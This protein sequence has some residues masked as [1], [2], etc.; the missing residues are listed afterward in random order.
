MTGLGTLPHYHPLYLGMA[1]IHGTERANAALN[2]CDLLIAVGARFSDRLN[3]TA[4]PKIIHIDVDKTEFGKNVAPTLT[5]NGDAKSVLTRL[6]PLSEG[7]VGGADWGCRPLSH[8]AAAESGGGNSQLILVTDVGNH[9]IAAAKAFPI[10]RPRQFISS[11]GLG[12]MGFG[13]GA[14]IG[15]ALGCPGKRVLLVTGDGSFHMDMAEFSTAVAEQL[16][17][18]VLVCNNGTLGM[19]DDMPFNR[20]TDFVKLADAFGAVGLTV[21]AGQDLEQTV[22]QALSLNRPCIIDYRM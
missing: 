9:Q 4:E 5:L 20:R 7:A 18:V 11:C 15:A 8:V 16:P 2:S 3:L 13:M 17:V 19:L 22:R 10:E 21:A 14:A 6:S 12:A 1:G